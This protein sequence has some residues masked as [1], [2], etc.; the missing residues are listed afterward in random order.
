MS[1]LCKKKN[2]R[3]QNKIKKF[4]GTHQFRP[5]YFGP[6]RKNQNFSPSPEISKKVCHIPV[7]QKHLEEIDFGATCYFRPRVIPLRPADLRI[8]AQKLLVRSW[9][10]PKN[11]SKIHS[12]HL[13]LFVFLS[14]ADTLIDACSPIHAQTGNF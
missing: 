1:I 7:G 13:K 9:T 6:Y 11:F 12:F 14:Q 3:F 2:A 4:K 10:G 8:S 5:Q